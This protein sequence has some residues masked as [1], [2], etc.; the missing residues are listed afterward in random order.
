MSTITSSHA[1]VA[2][3]TDRLARSVGQQKYNMWFDRSAR[4]NFDDQSRRLMVVVP[5]RFV[6]DWIDRNFHN[7]LRDAAEHEVGEGI[8]LELQ[9][10]AGSFTEVSVPPVNAAGTPAPAPRPGAAWRVTGLK[11]LR[12]DLGD[13]V[14]GPGNELAFAAASGFADETHGQANT[15]FIHGGCGLGKTHLLQ[16]ICRRWL[17]RHPSARVFYTTAEQFTNKFLATMRST[18]VEPF[19]RRIRGLELLAVDDVHFLAG[20][21][22]TQQEFL[23]TFDEINLC[24]ARVVMASDSHPKLIK[25]FGESLI[26][27]CLRG[28]VVQVEK[29]DMATRVRIIRAL[30]KRRN[31]SVLDSVIEVL[32]ARCQGSVRELEGTLAKLHALLQITVEHR[33]RANGDAIGHSLLNRLIE[34]ECVERPRK[35]VSF[36]T[37]LDTVSARRRVQRSEILG[38][39]RRR[40]TVEARSLVMYLARQLTPL[41]FPEIA[42]AMGR[43][44]H[45]TIVTACHRVEKDL[46]DGKRILA[47]GFGELPLVE[48][49]AQLKKA[50]A[51]G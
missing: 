2:R 30:A 1:M 23:H 29:P 38:Q 39:S 36:D 7:H 16:G 14:V 35:I 46:A 22:A 31:M 26:S 20:K 9:V 21:N 47:D 24:G 3:I 33:G 42:A 28:M 51:E 15:L 50:I 6:A 27:R 40:R 5:N 13:F 44:N 34:A 41:S 10:D 45:S 18:R 25:Q 48:I 17:F 8:D 43:S 11:R 37:I 49:I 19:R 12:H 32:A 4:L